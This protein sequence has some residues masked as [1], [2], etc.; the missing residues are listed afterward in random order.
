MLEV[1]EARKFIFA[2]EDYPSAWFKK[3][4]IFSQD[5]EEIISSLI[6][7]DPVLLRGAKGSG[8][9]VLLKEAHDRIKKES[10]TT[11]SV[12]LSLRNSLQLHNQDET[13]EKKFCELI[14][15]SVNLAL[16]ESW[17]KQEIFFWAMP[18]AAHLQ[19]ALVKLSHQLDRG[20]ILFFDDAVH[21]DREI[22]WERFF[23]I[24][25]VLSGG[26][27][28]CKASIYLDVTKFGSCV[29]VYRYTTLINLERDRD[30]FLTSFFLE[31]MTT[32][33]P[34]LLDES[35]TSET[36]DKTKL[37][38]FLGKAVIGNIRAFLLACNQLDEFPQIGL[39]QLN[40]CLIKIAGDYYWPLLEALK[41]ELGIYESFIELS[42]TLASEIYSLAAQESTY[43]VIIHRSLRLKWAKSFEIL[44]YAGFISLR[45]ASIDMKYGGPGSLFTLN[46]CNLLEKTPEPGLTS[47][48]FNVWLQKQP[49]PTEIYLLDI[50]S[51]L[52]M[53]GE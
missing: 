8:K 18:T 5:E 21:L 17:L 28:S 15:E 29:D 48:R 47:E 50:P 20:I 25:R 39:P 41:Q 11:F 51:S 42:M 7:H 49:E 43:L 34:T 13:Y 32:R 3:L 38:A 40:T 14:I 9:T 23:N 36:L 44:E 52:M 30:T 16:K 33:Y 10:S 12:Y 19:Q 24:F 53:N 37:A 22:S 45:Q 31:V 27:I 1:E 35:K 26:R 46:F 2:A 6:I 4:H